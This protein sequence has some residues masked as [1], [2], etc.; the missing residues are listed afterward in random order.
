[1]VKYQ[2]H[3]PESQERDKESLYRH[4]YHWWHFVTYLVIFV[5]EFSKELI[6]C[7]VFRGTSKERNKNRYI[8][9]LCI[10]V[11]EKKA[12]FYLQG[13]KVKQCNLNLYI[14]KSYRDLGQRTKM[15]SDIV[16]KSLRLSKRKLINMWLEI[17]KNIIAKNKLR[18][19]NCSLN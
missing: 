13:Y 6:Y 10:T 14:N 19:I 4:H 15:H 16:K 1:M 9:V 12:P 5:K 17:D 18:R 11:G 2:Y 3:S 8:T 7:I